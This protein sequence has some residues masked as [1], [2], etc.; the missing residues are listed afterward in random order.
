M[1]IIMIIIGFF[2]ISNINAQSIPVNFEDCNPSEFTMESD[3]RPE[4]NNDTLSIIDYLNEQIKHNADLKKTKGKVYIGIVVFEDGSLCC[5]FFNNMTNKDL[6]PILFKKIINE[7]PI[8]K[9][10]QLKD[11]P[12]IYMHQITLEFKKGKIINVL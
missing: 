12:T 11:K 3:K 7:M 10:G 1:K 4:W 2:I 6:D 9:P 8:W 5:R